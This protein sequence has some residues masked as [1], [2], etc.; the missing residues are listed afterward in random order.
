MYKNFMNDSTAVS[1]ITQLP[2]PSI[3]LEHGV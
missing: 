1:S 3:K 2:G